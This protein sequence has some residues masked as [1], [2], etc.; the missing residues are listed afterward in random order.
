MKVV[1]MLMIFIMSVC[2]FNGR[3]QVIEKSI[4]KQRQEICH[5][6]IYGKASW[7]G[8][9]FHNRK[10]ANGKKFNANDPSLVASPT[11]PLG[12]K[13]MAL[14]LKNGKTLKAVVS[15][16]G[17]YVHGRVADFSRAGAQKLGFLLAGVTD[18]RIEILRG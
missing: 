9:Y 3:Y 4:L 16:R 12:T 7:Y 17:P 11:L 8:D 5:K 1:K 10:M 6:A 14:N 13:I 15:D 2:V 18:I